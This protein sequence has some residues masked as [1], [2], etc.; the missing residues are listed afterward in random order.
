MDRFAGVKVIVCGVWVFVQPY[1]AREKQP[2]IKFLSVLS[3][4][5]LG[6][7]VLTV[8]WLCETNITVMTN[9]TAYKEGF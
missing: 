2:N 6:I 3:V 4:M 8:L 5:Y 1:K 7:T 9:V